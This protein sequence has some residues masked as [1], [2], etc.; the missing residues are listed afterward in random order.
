MIKNIKRSPNQKLKGEII[1]PPDKS[2]SH[3]SIIFAA[4]GQ[5]KST[6]NNLLEAK[7]CLSTLN[8]F[9][10]MGISSKKK[11]NT[12]IIEGNGI[13]GLQ[14]PEQPLDC[15][16]SGTTMRLL[17]GLLA[18]QNGEFV[19]DGDQSLRKRPMQRIIKPLS[20]MGAE[21][22][23]ERQKGFA[24]LTITGKKLKA[25]NYDLPIA[26]AQV[27]SSLLLANLYS[28]QKICLREPEISRDH[29]EIMM[30]ELGL[31]INKEDLKIE[32]K[33]SINDDIPANEYRVPGD[34]SQ[35][36]YFITAA[37]LIPNSELMIKGVNLNSSRTGFLKVI[38]N[39]GADFKIYDKKYINGEPTG[40]IFVKSSALEGITVSQDLVPS[41][42]DEIP[43]IALLALKADGTTKIRG[44]QELRVKESDRINVLKKGFET[45]NLDI[46]VWEDGFAIKGPQE[47]NESGVLDSHLDHRMAMTFTILGLITKYGIGLENYSCIDNSFPGFFDK[48]NKIL[49]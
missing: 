10:K 33:S 24:P 23:T 1:P 16:N 38:K 37:L 36:A 47:I 45:L 17:A 35:A 15:G 8:V 30:K 14:A 20:K 40:N 26:S 2:I 42:I 43:L 13:F 11:N 49:Y 19:L 46:K 41:M 6:I 31:N 32:F 7:D 34:F 18:G 27:K 5:G 9:K 29:T 4:I 39:M 3:R 28:N 48:L 25:I 22:K 44:V 21:I 12:Y